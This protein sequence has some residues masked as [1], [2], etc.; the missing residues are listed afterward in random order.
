MRRPAARAGLSGVMYGALRPGLVGHTQVL[1]DNPGYIQ[2]ASGD[3]ILIGM[4]S[5]GITK[6]KAMI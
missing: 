4:A 1:L 3:K 5:T 2:H 6:L